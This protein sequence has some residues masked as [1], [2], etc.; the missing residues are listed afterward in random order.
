MVSQVTMRL[1]MSP[2]GTITQHT[3]VYDEAV[4]LQVD[5]PL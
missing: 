5:P 1:F 3:P 2:L 4:I